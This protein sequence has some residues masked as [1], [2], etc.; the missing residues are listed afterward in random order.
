MQIVIR[1]TEENDG[2]AVADISAAAFATLCEVYRSSAS[3]VSIKRNLASEL[4]RLVAVADDRV[5]GTLEYR[6]E[7]DRV[8]LIGLGV[9]PDFRRQGVARHLIRHLANIARQVGASKL[10]LYTVRETGN[11]SVFEKL[12]FGVIREEPA[13]QFESDRFDVLNEV[14]MEKILV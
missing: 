11:V 7:A 2:Q 4:T 14:F 1:E 6:N 8:H 5:V 9:H 12:G 10:S 3:T 13:Q